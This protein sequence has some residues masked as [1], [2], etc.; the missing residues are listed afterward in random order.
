MRVC[1]AWI[2]NCQVYKYSRLRSRSIKSSL[3]VLSS[4]PTL[5][6]AR[7]EESRVTQACYGLIGIIMSDIV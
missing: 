6:L 3:L 5:S 2:Y 7:V 1:N 4:K